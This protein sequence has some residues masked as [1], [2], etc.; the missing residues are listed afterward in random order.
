LTFG[1]IYGI[2]ER[3]TRG[4]VVPRLGNDGELHLRID[5]APER[6]CENCGREYGPTYPTQR[7]C[8]PECRGEY[9]NAELR[10]ARRLWAQTGKPK[11]V[12]EECRRNEE[13]KGAT[14]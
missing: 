5:L 8:S 14:A 13:A 6:I 11:E 4:K 10:A 3:K 9:R 7:W 1:S 2:I 12:F